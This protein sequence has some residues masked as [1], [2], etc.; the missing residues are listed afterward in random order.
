M[1]D[2]LKSVKQSKKLAMMHTGEH[3][4]FKCLE[5]QVKELKLEKISLD[6]EESSLF[7]MA[8]GL[9]WDIIFKAEQEANNII[10]ENK[11][12]IAHETDKKGIS[13][14][15]GLRIKLER[16]KEEKIRIIEIKNHDFSACSG[17]HCKS[18]GEVRNLLVT[19]FRK[20]PTGYEIRFKVDAEKEL[21][22]LAATARLAMDALGAEQDKVIPTIKNLKDEL[23]RCKKAMK[24][25]KIEAKEELVNGFHFIYAVFED[26][27]KKLLI[28]KANELMKNKS[29]LCFLNKSDTLQVVIMC[30]ADSGKDAS[31]IVKALNE[32]LGGKGGG[33]QAFAMCSVNEGN[34]DKVLSAV[35]DMIN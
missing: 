22:G 25:Q 26:M 18:T 14:F 8:E 9:S 30:S 31:L 6:E 2:E 28:D 11:E 13:K 17:E 34:A 19:K 10:K 16:I 32:K 27:D 12:V 7:V 23:E 5:K 33:K 35:K 29:V 1:E 20:A 3:I 24:S 4:F 15:P 21:F